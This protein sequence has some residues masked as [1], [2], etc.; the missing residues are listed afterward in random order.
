MKIVKIENNI[1]DVALDIEVNSTHSYLLS[2][3]IIS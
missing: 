3:Y 1:S 2:N